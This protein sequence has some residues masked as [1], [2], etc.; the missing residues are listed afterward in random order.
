MAREGI[1]WVDRRLHGGSGESI[2]RCRKVGR[3]CSGLVILMRDAR[4]CCPNPS[5]YAHPAL[6]NMKSSSQH[7][8]EALWMVQR[9]VS[10]KV[11]FFDTVSS[12]TVLCDPSE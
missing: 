11:P 8:L 9:C 2:L 5:R 1:R 12:V 4:K 6:T 10:K 7:V 3:E